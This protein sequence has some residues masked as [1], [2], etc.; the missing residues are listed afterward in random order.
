MV[1][2]IEGVPARPPDPISKA[3]QD[4]DDPDEDSLFVKV[5]YEVC[6]CTICGNLVYNNT[7]SRDSHL[8]RADHLK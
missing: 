8:N 1:D 6:Q 2:L 3:Y 4:Y 5:S 7:E